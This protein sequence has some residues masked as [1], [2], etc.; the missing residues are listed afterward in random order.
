MF[1]FYSSVAVGVCRAHHG[2]RW[3][4]VYSSKDSSNRTLIPK[5]CPSSHS[6]LCEAGIVCSAEQVVV[7]LYRLGEEVLAK[8]VRYDLRVLYLHIMYTP[9]LVNLSF[10]GVSMHHQ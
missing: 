7:L 2:F 5:M 10:D 8:S 1:I 4:G 9:A 6:C 3:F